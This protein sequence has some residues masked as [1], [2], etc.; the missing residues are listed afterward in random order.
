[1][2]IYH[3]K[4][5]DWIKMQLSNSLFLLHSIETAY[6]KS[7]PV[8]FVSSSDDNWR[9][10]CSKVGWLNEYP[11]KYFKSLFIFSKTPKTGPRFE[12]FPLSVRWNVTDAQNCE[13][14]ARRALE[15]KFLSRVDCNSEWYFRWAWISIL[16]PRPYFDFR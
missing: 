8:E 2:I 4:N 3:G 15:G 16:N 14:Q 5:R 11:P 9:N 10:I 1:M 12:L 13:P 7:V 6:L